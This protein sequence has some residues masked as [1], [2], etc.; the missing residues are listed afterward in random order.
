MNQ[1]FEAIAKA[2]KDTTE[3]V[4][5]HKYGQDMKNA[6]KYSAGAA[7][8]VYELKKT[9]QSALKKAAIDNTFKNEQNR[10]SATE[11]YFGK[12]KNGHFSA[13]PHYGIYD[14][15]PVEEQYHYVQDTRMRYN[16]PRYPYYGYDQRGFY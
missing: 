2:T 3:D 13:K 8:N 10:F 15:P 4:L 16:K 14:E 5:E 11:K 7:Y 12:G 6:F 1:A 9:P